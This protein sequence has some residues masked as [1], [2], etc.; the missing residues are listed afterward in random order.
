MSAQDV[1]LCVSETFL[2]VVEMG[3]NEEISWYGNHDDDDDDGGGGG[4]DHEDD[5]DTAVASPV[6]IAEYLDRGGALV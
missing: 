1:Y 2:D 5:D 6:R 3:W 4:V